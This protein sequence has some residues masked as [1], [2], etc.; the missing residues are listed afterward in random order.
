MPDKANDLHVDNNIK[1]SNKVQKKSN[2]YRA[3]YTILQSVCQRRG[4]TC[5]KSQVRYIR[6]IVCSFCVTDRFGFSK[7]RRSSINRSRIEL[8][9][10]K[11]W[12]A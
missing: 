5:K 4:A 9:F 12:S 6:A 8:R 3:I 10:G 7:S 2:V 11:N 1:N